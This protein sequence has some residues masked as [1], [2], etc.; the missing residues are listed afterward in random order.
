MMHPYTDVFFCFLMNTA[1]EYCM[2]ICGDSGFIVPVPVLS[3]TIYLYNYSVQRCFCF[4]MNTAGLSAYNYVYVP[5]HLH[6]IFCQHLV[7]LVRLCADSDRNTTLLFLWK[8]SSGW[9]ENY[10]N[11]SNTTKITYHLSTFR[12]H[13]G[14]L[15]QDWLPVPV[16][17]M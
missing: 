11:Y 1:A 16:V 10:I 4:R 9:H 12:L 3:S 17:S 5:E 13:V 6:Y 15:H 7:W 8:V 14:S 2:V